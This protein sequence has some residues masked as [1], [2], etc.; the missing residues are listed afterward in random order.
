MQIFSYEGTLLRYEIY[1]SGTP[2]LMLHGWGVDHRIMTGCFEPVF[3]D[4]INSYRRIYVDLP[5]MGLSEVSEKIKNSDDI[6]EVLLAF[7]DHIIPNQDFLLAGESFGGYLARGIVKQ[8]GAQISGILL[9]CPLM[10]PGHRKGTY[11]PLTVMEKDENFLCTLSEQERSSFEYINVILTKNVWARF[12]E[13]IYDAL[14]HQNTHFL[15]EVL[16][17]AF[18]FDANELEQPFDKPCLILV[19]KQDTEVGYRD[20]FK[21][22]DQYTNATYVALNRAGHNLQIEQPELFYQIVIKWLEDNASLNL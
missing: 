2:V 4:Q 5:G 1:G 20:Q 12:K 11:E 13:D 10:Y 18:S 16:D 17:A 3:R 19:G 7:I 9:L 22:L 21:L 14:L 8:R 6:L 15:F